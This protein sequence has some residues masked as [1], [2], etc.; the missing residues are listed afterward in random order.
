MIK[1]IINHSKVNLVLSEHELRD[2]SLLN[3][4]T[5]M[6]ILPNG[7]K[8]FEDSLQQK[9][10]YVPEIAFCSRLQSRKRVDLFLSIA[11]FA[12]A[13][14]IGANFSIYGPDGGELSRTLNSIELQKLSNVRYMGS[15]QPEFVSKILAKVDLLVLP[16]ENEPFP[17]IVL[18]SLSVGTSVLIMPSC[19]IASLIGNSFPEMVALEESEEA[20]RESFLRL[21]K[22]KS[23]NKNRIQLRE[24]CSAKFGIS[25][26]VTELEKIDSKA[27]SC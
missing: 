5:H 18:E 3:L 4:K 26:I 24:F 7:I 19:G 16:S 27:I 8:V 12:K 6:K 22:S 2:V 14:N 1:R 13:E 15:V 23:L 21:I 9:S 11:K 25:P 20:L 10:N 17:M